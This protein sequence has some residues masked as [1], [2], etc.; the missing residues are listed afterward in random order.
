M[1][2]VVHNFSAVSDSDVKAIATYIASFTSRVPPERAQK[3]R[4]LLARAQSPQPLPPAGNDPG[5]TIYASTCALCHGEG[6]DLAYSGAALDLALSTAVAAATPRNFV[7]VVLYGLRPEEGER[8][9]WMPGFAGALTDGELRSLADYVRRQFAQ[10][11]AWDKV[12]QAVKDARSSA[13]T[14]AEARRRANDTKE[15]G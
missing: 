3:A 1:A 14:A 10:A 8:G 2:P 7:N 6:R 12:A 4:A 11:P 5:A 15:R 13:Q 9:R